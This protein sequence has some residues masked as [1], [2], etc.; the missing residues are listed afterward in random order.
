MFDAGALGGKKLV[1]FERLYVDGIQV[2][3]HTDLNDRA[4]TVFIKE[5]EIPVPQKTKKKN[6]PETGDTA[7]I[8]RVF[9]GIFLAG[10]V[11]LTVGKKKKDT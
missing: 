4:Q 2:A 7:P 11:L 6:T 3:S 10:T 5:K 8:G 9:L 1:V